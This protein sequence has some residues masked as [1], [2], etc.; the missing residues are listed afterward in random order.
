MVIFKY[1]MKHLMHYMLLWSVI[2]GVCIITFYPIYTSFILTGALLPNNFLTENT[3]MNTLGI[4]MQYL[5]TPLGVYGFLTSFVMLACAINA[6]YLGIRIFTGEYLHKTADFLMTKPFS[7][8]S[9]LRSK[10]LAALVV[11]LMISLTYILASFAII[12]V[13]YSNEFDGTIFSLLSFSILFSQ[14][15][16][17]S[18]GMMIGS[19]FP[20]IK[21]PIL[22]ASGIA[23]FLYIVGSFSRK[24]NNRF[25][26]LFSPFTYFDMA[27]IF[28]NV[29]YSSL[30]MLILPLALF[31][32]CSIAR[33]NFSRKDILYHE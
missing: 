22:T 31:L 13:S 11:I 29:G 12:M 3:F 4:N 27:D 19:F 33:R 26:Q 5:L 25:I 15:I 10:F 23:F 30:S 17:L 14:V 32:F 6:T 24:I 9:I 21:A 7:R 2:L 1:E 8:L 20:R 18:I 28:S 16:F